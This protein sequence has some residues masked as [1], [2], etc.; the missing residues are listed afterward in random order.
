MVINDI[1]V[2]REKATTSISIP[3]GGPDNLS[4]F[5]LLLGEVKCYE[6]NLCFRASVTRPGR[7]SPSHRKFHLVLGIYRFIS[8]C[9]L[10]ME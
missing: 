4:F 6:S 8:F 3:L 7:Q 2:G 1:S 10:A 9:L 5:I